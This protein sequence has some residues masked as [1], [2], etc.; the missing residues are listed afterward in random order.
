MSRILAVGLL[1][2]AMLL[3]W[4]GVGLFLLLRPAHFGNL[5]HDNLALFPEVRPA[6]WGKKL[7]LR[8]L[9]AGL[10]VFAF[11]FVLRLRLMVE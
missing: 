2:L 10:L 9:G 6:D 4:S 1:Y 11:R 5:I 8:L 3:A 7:F